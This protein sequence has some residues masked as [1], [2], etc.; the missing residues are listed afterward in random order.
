MRV[1]CPENDDLFDQ[2]LYS[3]N[4]YSQLGKHVLMGDYN[5]RTSTLID[6]VELDG[7]INGTD[8]INLL[9][10]TY[11]NDIKL[12][13]RNNSDKEI[14]EQGKHL[15]DLCIETK[16]RM[17]NVRNDGDSLGYRTYY[18]PRGSS[19]IDYIICSEDILHDF[20]FLH[21]FPPNELSDH[22]IIWAGFNYNIIDTGSCMN[23]HSEYDYD[24][25][26][27]KFNLE[28]G[29]KTDFI[30]SLEDS[31]SK[32]TISQFVLEVNNPAAN[33]N[34]LTDNLNNIII[35]AAYK[36]FHFKQFTKKK[37]KMKYKQKWFQKRIEQY[38]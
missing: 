9:P 20:V 16:L 36:T 4:K 31:N 37:G 1:N 3:I 23:D 27:G 5:S 35:N 21:V 17:L 30:T 25:L 12:K 10:E 24:L 28:T 26:P 19:A 11:T 7:N 38:W 29:S 2:L 18:S 13:S 14:N 22:S 32:N 34:V 8:H 15:I 33:I 6:Y